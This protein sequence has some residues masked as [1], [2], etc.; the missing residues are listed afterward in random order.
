MLTR[1]SERIHN[2]MRYTGRCCDT[3][4]VLADRQFLKICLLHHLCSYVECIDLHE[5]NELVDYRKTNEL[6][7]SW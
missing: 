3:P 2:P 6:I 5:F 4:L 1:S 7:N